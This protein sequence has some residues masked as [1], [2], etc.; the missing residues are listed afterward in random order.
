M[1]SICKDT[2]SPKPVAATRSCGGPA[3][4]ALNS[5]AFHM[6]NSRPIVAAQLSNS[7][8]H[9][10]LGHAF[11][12]PQKSYMTLHRYVGG[13]G[14]L[15]DV[16]LS[17]SLSLLPSPHF[18]SLCVHTGTASSEA[19]SY[20]VFSIWD[21]W[22]EDARTHYT[23]DPCAPRAR[24]GNPFWHGHAPVHVGIQRHVVS[25]STCR[26][27]FGHW[28]LPPS[29]RSSTLDSNPYALEQLDSS[30]TT[31]KIIRCHHR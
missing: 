26:F 14:Q 2:L 15:L 1:R 25:E 11:V 28:G 17:P 7:E 8:G 19:R 10:R 24:T 27:R 22:E 3:A 23:G 12:R 4:A 6:E 18:A 21:S 29:V 13:S 9:D 30:S 31:I 16:L 5:I 20:T